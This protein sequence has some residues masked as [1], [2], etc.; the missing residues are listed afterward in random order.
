MRDFAEVNR[1]AWDTRTPVHLTSAFYDVAAFK[2]GGCTLRQP[3][4][5]L[6]GDVRG[7]RLLHLQCH[8][9]LDTLS[10]ARRGAICTGVDFSAAAIAAARALGAETK[11]PATFVEADVQTLGDRFARSFD[12]VVAT[13]GVICWLHD[14]EGWT[15][16]IR[17]SL[18]PGGRF[19]LVEFHP[20]LDPL[21][22]GRVSGRPT[23]FGDSTAPDSTG[24]DSTA[25]DG[26][27][28]APQRTQGTYTDP[29]APIVYDEYRFQHPVGEV[30]NALIDAGLRLRR[31]E[32]YPYA[33]Y[34]ILHELECHRD[35][36]W[37]FPPPH[38]PGRLPLM[39]ALVADVEH[40]HG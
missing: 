14:L 4:L 38:P 36:L 26:T 23:Y 40:A 29:D 37:R 27:A 21:F 33:T 32:E 6:A 11:L 25:S 31:L 9:G 1:R 34:R 7:R 10:W 5:A 30:A 13:Y 20:L 15:R 28:P 16:G 24:P 22:G 8:F 3:E 12:V 35:G 39:Y 19:I 2:A 17:G 18:A